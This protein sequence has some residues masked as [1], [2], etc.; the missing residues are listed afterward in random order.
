MPS[1]ASISANTPATPRGIP[2]VLQ[3]ILS[4]RQTAV[5]QARQRV[6][7]EEWKRQAQQ[8]ERRDFLQALRPVRPGRS[9][10]LPAVIAELKRA[11]PSRGL[12][13]QDFDVAAL[14]AGYQA[15]GAAALSVLTEETH[16]QGRLE[17]LAEAR[18]ATRLPLLR[19]DFIFSSYQIWEA[20]AAGADAIL[21]IAAMLDDATWAAL[22]GTAR[23]AGVAALCE[24]HDQEEMQRAIRLGADCIGVNNRDLHTFTVDT[25]CALG[26]APLL[27]PTTLGVAESGLKTRADLHAITAAGLHAALIG[28]TCMTAPVPARAL[29]KLLGGFVKVCGLTT[30]A[31]VEAVAA[32]GADAAGFVFADSPRAITPE[33]ARPLIAALPADVLRVGLFRGADTSTII[34]I[35]AECGLDRVQLHGAYTTADGAAIASHLPVWR[36]LAV[37]ANAAEIRAWAPHAERFVLDAA[38]AGRTGGNGVSFDWDT[39]P[40]LARAFPAL[41]FIVAGGLN[42]SNVA[43]AIAR[44]GA[45]A[46]DAA[47]GL[48]NAPG[49]QPGKNAAAVLAFAHAARE[50]FQAL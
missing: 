27:P 9:P 4:E 35:A 40:A 20:A 13:R 28:E 3:Q 19:K 41:R 36:A 11:S 31:D 33:R 44:S 42:P 12:L 39:V 8:R 50:A 45:F 30:A 25:G 34:R 5:Q 46:V 49:G 24:V 43:T 32:A 47:S 16:F 38:V 18:A 2:S 1:T 29:T 23:E 48:E 26:L 21:L 6:P 7:E 37:P 22:L 15:A 10:A 17:Y 14:A